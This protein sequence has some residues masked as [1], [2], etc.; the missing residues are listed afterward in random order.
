MTCVRSRNAS[1][2][3]TAPGIC[4]VSTSEARKVVKEFKGDKPLAILV[5]SNITGAGEEVH[6]LVEDPSGRW[7]AR[8]RFMLQLGS[9]PVSDMEGKPRKPVVAGSI[10]VVLT[11]AKRHTDA[12]AWLYVLKNA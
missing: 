1:K 8:R 9:R 12:E 2:N 3:S 11:Y 7:Q 4:L 10:K 5:P 6:V